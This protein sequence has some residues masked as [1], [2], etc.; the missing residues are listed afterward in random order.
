[1][2]EIALGE[3]LTLAEEEAHLLLAAMEPAQVLLARVAMER[4]LLSLVRP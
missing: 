4:P 3:D 2:V 1:M